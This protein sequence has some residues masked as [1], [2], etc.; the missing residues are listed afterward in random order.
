MAYSA[1]IIDD[2]WHNRNIFEIALQHAG[3]AVTQAEGAEDGFALL[4]TERFDLLVLDLHM[5][6][7]S[8][9]DV[10]EWVKANPDLAHMVVLVV[11]ANP[12]RTAR[13]EEQA[14]YIMNK[15]IDLMDFSMFVKRLQRA[16]DQRD[17]AARQS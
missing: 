6:K 17:E 2:N 11:T 16:I 13:I 10:L 4:E 14:D 5:P 3:Y 7:I 8:G 9:E 1:L 15:P 12:A